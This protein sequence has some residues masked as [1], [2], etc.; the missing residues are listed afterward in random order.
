HICPRI[1]AWGRPCPEWRISYMSAFIRI[2]TLFILIFTLNA[3]AQTMRIG[4]SETPAVEVNEAYQ[5]S[6]SGSFPVYNEQLTPTT[7]NFR[8]QW[9]EENNVVTGIYTDNYYTAG[10]P[11]PVSGSVGDQASNLVPTLPQVTHIISTINV[12]LPQPGII[13]GSV[14]ATVTP[15]DTVGIDAGSHNIAALMSTDT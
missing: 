7:V 8:I 4:L 15:K 12:L 2:S 11:A 10:P 14:S 6:I 13:N 9:N 5:H 1:V 3:Q